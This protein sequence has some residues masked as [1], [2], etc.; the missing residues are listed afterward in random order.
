[1]PLIFLT[2]Q[3]VESPWDEVTGDF[4]GIS[5][6]GIQFI[7]TCTF[8]SLSMFK[9]LLRTATRGI[10]HKKHDYESQLTYKTGIFFCESG[11]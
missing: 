6:N 3:V 4:K 1:M 7:S 2:S 5:S 8:L 10:V 9:G 11:F